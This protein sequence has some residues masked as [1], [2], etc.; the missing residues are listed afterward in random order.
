MLLRDRPHMLFQPYNFNLLKCRY[1]VASLRGR[2]LQVSYNTVQITEAS[3][4]DLALKAQ[5][6]RHN[7][8]EF[9]FKAQHQIC[10]AQ[11]C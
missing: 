8:E 6:L 11:D 7:V 3:Y 5:Y 4:Q 10:N 9:P 1:S 2:V